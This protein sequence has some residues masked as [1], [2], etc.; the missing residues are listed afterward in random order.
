MKLKISDSLSIPIEAVTQTFAEIGRKG[1]GKTYLAT[2]IAEQMLDAE[3]QVIAIDPVGNWWGLRVASDG[4]SKGKEIFVIGGENGDVSLTPEAGARIARLLVEKRISAVLDVSGFRQGERKRFASDFAEEFFH[5]KKTQRSPVHIFIE[6]AQLF[7]PQ[8]VG[9]DE[10]RMVGAWESIVRLGRNYGIGASLVTQRPQ[11]VNKEVLS[12]VECL[13]V[14]QVNGSHERKALEEWVQEAGADRELVGRLPG[15]ARGVGFIWSPSWLRTFRMVHFSKKVTFDA[16]ATPEV[17]HETKATRLSTIDVDALRADLEEVIK[18]AEKDDPKALR[19]QIAELQR[20]L[21]AKPKAAAER[22]EVPTLKDS[23][24]DRLE[25]LASKFQEIGNVSL[26]TSRALATM[27]SR[28]AQ[29]MKG[30]APVQASAHTKSTNSVYAL[31]PSKKQAEISNAG[32]S[33]AERLILTV[34]S[35]YPQGRSKIQVALIA[36]YAHSGGSFSNAIGALRSQGLI[37]GGNELLCITTA[38]VGMVGA[39][40]P[41]PLGVELLRK[42]QRELGKAEREILDVLYEAHPRPLTKTDIAAATPSHYEPSGGSFNNAIGK[43]R[44]LDLIKGRREM[45]LSEELVG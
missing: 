22:V 38:G 1:A 10:A 7:I 11:S 8:R 30:A 2:M 18:Q 27:I 43:L 6:E 12:Q 45:V 20:D 32:L 25:K 23:Q 39:V 9:P 31:I 16:S 5:L 19:R 15:L 21:N 26:E 3:A 33:K 29:M 35:Q 34:L 41:L 36:G 13:F 28:A 4:K 37:E 24:I 44:T 40:E 14:L 42:W 17:G